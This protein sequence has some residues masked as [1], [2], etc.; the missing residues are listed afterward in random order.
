M[1]ELPEV[2]LQ[3][4]YLRARCIDATIKSYGY[5][6]KRQFKATRAK[7]DEAAAP[8][9]DAFLHGNTL[10]RF[11]QRG[12]QLVIGTD[13]GLIVSHLMLSG[14]WSIESEP[15]IASYK[16][17]AEPPPEWSRGVWLELEDGRT[18]TMHTPRW[19]ATTSI[20]PGVHEPG[21]VAELTK[22][23]PEAIVFAE[24]DAAFAARPWTAGDLEKSASR[25]SKPIKAL[26]LDQK[27]VCGLG[28]RYVCE[29][30]YNARIH[31]E[32]VARE[33]EG[34]ELARVYRACVDILKVA[35]ES[36]LDYERF[37]QVYRTET[38]KKGRAVEMIQVAG[39]DT[40]FVPEVQSA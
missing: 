36:D 30:L 24:T 1:P 6:G 11:S 18:L 4:R 35:V 9:L 25:S 2:N 31:P 8:K 40:F 10:R 28:N 22:G 39:R 14:R 21:K 29:A 3:V 12:K 32:R 17:W 38:D 34:D 15:L 19:Q 20:H 37:T 16:T 23:G 27:Q 33:L 26:L 5:K 7:G 13:R